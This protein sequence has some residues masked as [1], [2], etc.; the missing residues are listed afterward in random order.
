MAK[1]TQRA[2]IDLSVVFELSEAEVGALD[3]LAGYGT[4]AFLKVFYEKLGQ[5]YMTP[6]EAGL[7]SLFESV[8]DQLPPM[9]RAAKT[10]REAFAKQI[11]GVS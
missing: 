6:Y 10:A 2:T 11:A 1:L 9:L 8:R 3:A 5:A 4:D 7:R